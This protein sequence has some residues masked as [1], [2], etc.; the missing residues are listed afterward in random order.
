MNKLGVIYYANRYKRLAASVLKK[1]DV[2]DVDALDKLFTDLAKR[3]ENRN[4]GY[5][6]VLKLENRRGDNAPR[7]LL[8]LAD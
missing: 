4:G 6:R 2:N 8:V 3:F 5:L 1:Y 7:R